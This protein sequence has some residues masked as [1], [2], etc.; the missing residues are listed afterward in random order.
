MSG[1]VPT[2]PEALAAL[3][4]VSVW[5]FVGEDDAIVS[6]ESSKQFVAALTKQK[7]DA[8][9]TVFPDTNHFGVPQKA[10]LENGTALLDWLTA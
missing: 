1:S 6:P 8:R 10:W 3:R 7:A 9:I 4:T 2:T 5:A